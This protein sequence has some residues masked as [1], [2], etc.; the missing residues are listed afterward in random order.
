[1]KNNTII[2]IVVIAFLIG[3]VTGYIFND[4]DHEIE[5]A[6][7]NTGMQET[8]NS[9]MGR[10]QDKNGD[11]FDKAF[12]T[13]MIVHHEGAVVMAK[14]AELNAKHSEIKEMAKE[15]IDAQTREIIQMR[16]WLDLWYGIE[17]STHIDHSTADVM[18]HGIK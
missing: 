4:K 13:E 3:H 6:T 14:T 8:M 2:F 5:D 10:L 16:E 9:M 7:K 18:L 1:M 15:I 12:I 17:T 11:D